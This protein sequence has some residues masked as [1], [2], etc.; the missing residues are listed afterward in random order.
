[1]HQACMR[2]EA[3]RLTS[4]SRSRSKGKGAGLATSCFFFFSSF[5]CFFSL[6]CQFT[7]WF[8]DSV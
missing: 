3:L 6:S 7:V 5:A 2:T 8:K 4:K 1:M